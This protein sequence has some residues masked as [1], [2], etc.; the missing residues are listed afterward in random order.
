MSMS[1]E[2][3]MR[4]V[5]DTARLYG[6]LVY[7][8]RP[9]RVRDNR[10]ATAM[11]GDAGLPDLVLARRGR[12]ILAELKTDTGR[13]GPHQR[14]WLKNLGAHGRLWRPAQWDV[15]VRELSARDAER[16]WVDADSEAERIRDAAQ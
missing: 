5:I 4:R 10:W 2:D 11:Q 6:W 8:Q 3:F 7:H 15:I 9:T 14:Q 13:T 12:V 16:D 1:E